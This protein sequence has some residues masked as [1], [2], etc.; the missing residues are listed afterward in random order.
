MWPDLAKLGGGE[1][2]RSRPELLGVYSNGNLTKD[3]QSHAVPAGIKLETTKGFTG[4]RRD[5][6]GFGVF[7]QWNAK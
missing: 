4:G 2:P 1:V 7:T 5:E 3:A 6:R